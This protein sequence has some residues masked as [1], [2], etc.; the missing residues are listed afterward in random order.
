ME[1]FEFSVPQKIIFGKGSLNKIADILKQDGIKKV[2]LLSGKL[3]T[4]MG[5][6]KSVED[7][8]DSCGVSHELF[9]DIEANP[10]VETVDRAVEAFK[11]SGAEYII[12][13][14]GGSPMD[15]AKAVGVVA[16]YGATVYDYVGAH[17]VKGDIVPIIAIPTTAGTGSEVTSF[18]VITDRA[19][20]FKMTIFS[21]MVIPKYAI[22]D[23]EMIMTMPKGVAAATGLDA[24]VHALESYLSKWANPYSEAMSEKA[25]ELIGRS[26]R[27]FVEDRK[28]ASSASDMLVGSMIAGLAMNCSR[29]GDVHA[30]AHPVGGYFNVAH[31][32][33]NAI[34]L[35]TV[36]GFNSQQYDVKY[37]KIYR[38]IAKEPKAEFSADLLVE[39]LRALNLELGIP[40]GL[41]EVGVK[42]ELIA[43]MA[44]DAMTSGNIAV[45]PRATTIEDIIKM[46]EEAM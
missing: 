8:L 27:A 34:L 37:E 39:E 33:A 46:Y 45:N 24:F 38:Y 13:L 30:M 1:S 36:V 16:K 10:S 6:V 5:V 28:N 17:L 19:K 44:K 35:P 41:A 14:G 26:I 18:S 32:V 9:N 22:L 7:I 15:V 25:M 12:A 31:G 40:K 20:N 4:K 3:L 43:D 21:H 2:M 11:Q 42:S 23:P 29:L